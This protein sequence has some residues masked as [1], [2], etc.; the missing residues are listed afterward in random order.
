MYVLGQ[1]TS[2]SLWNDTETKKAQ[3]RRQIFFIKNLEISFVY[4]SG[5]A[6]AR[7]LRQLL[8][9]EITNLKKNSLQSAD[10]K[11]LQVELPRAKIFLSIAW[12]S[13]SSFLIISHLAFRTGVFVFLWAEFF[14]GC[15]QTD[16]SF[17][18][19]FP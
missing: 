19:G 4:N 11:W 9:R 3:I 7:V 13:G 17:L 8:L 14:A 15:Q 1:I 10:R 12:L 18:I 5:S 6:P 2:A 16:S